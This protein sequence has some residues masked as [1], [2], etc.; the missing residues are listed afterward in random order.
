MEE[1]PVY[2]LRSPTQQG[3]L[4]LLLGAAL[5]A[6]C[7]RFRDG[8]HK[9]MGEDVQGPPYPHS[10]PTS[11]TWPTHRLRRRSFL[12][13]L[14]SLSMYLMLFIGLSGTCWVDESEGEKGAYLAV[15]AE[16]VYGRPHPLS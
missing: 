16:P 2:F 7:C 8:E 15:L 1:G 9:D 12:R 5:P 11:A 4:A 6:F 3:I 13:F 14:I 10:L